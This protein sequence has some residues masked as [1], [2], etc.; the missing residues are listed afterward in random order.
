MAQGSQVVAAPSAARERAASAVVLEL[1]QRCRSLDPAQFI[2]WALDRLRQLIPFHSAFWA[3]GAFTASRSIIF[4][5]HYLDN[6]PDSLLA[7]YFPIAQE[8]PLAEKVSASLGK[9]ATMDASS[10]Q[11]SAPFSAYLKKYDVC[12]GMSTMVIDPVT[13]LS[14]AVS[15]Y[16]PFGSSPFTAAECEIKEQ[17]V[18]HLIETWSANRLAHLTR[19]CDTG[20]KIPYSAAI[21]DERAVLHVADDSFPG[22]LRTEWPEWQGPAVPV[23]LVQMLRQNESAAFVGNRIVIGATRVKDRVLLRARA[24]A[25]W[26]RIGAR[27]RTVA[28]LAAR[29]LSRK[30]IAGKLRLSP[31]TVH[32][33]LSAVYEKLQVRSKTQLAALVALFDW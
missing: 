9:P 23:H 29:G 32:N 13:R 24:V 15:L 1:H 16:R 4:H 7:D 22:M 11:G 18:P 19:L 2:P 20:H 3:A 26:D 25:S 21:V 17:I 12:Y 33:H 6:Q 10:W 8:D 14:T 30:E 5:S 28:Q 31:S 27:E